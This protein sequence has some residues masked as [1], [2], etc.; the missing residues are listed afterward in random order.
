MGKYVVKSGGG[1]G[2]KKIPP[3]VLFEG[4]ED[5]YTL[6]DGFTGFSLYYTDIN[7]IM[8]VFAST[9]KDSGSEAKYGYVLEKS[10]GISHSNGNYTDSGI[11]ASKEPIDLTN[12]NSIC[13]DFYGTCDYYS[14]SELMSAYF[15]IDKPDIL[16][17][18]KVTYDWTGWDDI[19]MYYRKYGKYYFD[20]SQLTGKHDLCF[21]IYHGN[22]SG[23]YSNGI[24]IYKIML[25]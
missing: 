9:R 13:I 2:Y 22:Y 12:Y 10:Y 25:M 6:A 11:I 24:K 8:N 20:I 18:S 14:S 19:Y 1:G 23:G 15:K 5:G 4:T 17:Q 16:P 21:G 3:L 7:P